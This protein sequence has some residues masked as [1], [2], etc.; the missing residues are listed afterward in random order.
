ML[1]M[2]YWQL[3]SPKA[4][5]QSLSFLTCR[6][7]SF[8][9]HFPAREIIVLNIDDQECGFHEFPLLLIGLQSSASI[10]KRDSLR[11]VLSGAWLRLLGG[12]CRV[13]GTSSSVSYNLYTYAA[14]IS[15]SLHHARRATA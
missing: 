9:F 10:S 3:L 2:N 14:H 11:V 1:D 12:T 4:V 7:T 6:N 8:K 5:E 15:L 13:P